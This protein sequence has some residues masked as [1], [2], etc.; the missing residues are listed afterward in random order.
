VTFPN[1]QDLDILHPFQQRNQIIEGDIPDFEDDV[2]LERL[3]SRIGAP[4]NKE[5]ALFRNRGP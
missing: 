4:S 5:P 3:A 1:I 2:G